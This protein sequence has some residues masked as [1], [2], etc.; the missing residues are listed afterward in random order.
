M[1][2][3]G[4][5]RPHRRHR[6]PLCYRSAKCE[7]DAEM[8]CEWI[9]GIVGDLVEESENF[10]DRELRTA[11][12][13][14]AR[15][16]ETKRRIGAGLLSQWAVWVAES[17]ETSTRGVKSPLF[18]MDLTMFLQ[19]R[20]GIDRTSPEYWDRGEVRIATAS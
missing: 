16:E 2:R 17:L 9:L 13:E 14:R 8:V 20:F 15:I 12:L 6:Y 11:G 7:Q 5:V 3:V 18:S 10:L 1:D 19:K 4:L